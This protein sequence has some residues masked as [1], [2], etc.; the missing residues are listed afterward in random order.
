MQ[1][2]PARTLA[3]SG[4]PLGRARSGGRTRLAP[5]I[6]AFKVIGSHDQPTRGRPD[7]V[8]CGVNPSSPPPRVW[9]KSRL[10]LLV[11][12]GWGGIPRLLHADVL[13]AGP[14]GTPS[15]WRTGALRD[16]L[17]PQFSFDPEGG[18]SGH[19]G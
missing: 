10:L 6:L 11:L 2:K 17:R 9:L 18:R 3:F 15:G 1:P 19:G 13:A 5:V 8:Y 12:L 16:E 14:E 7:M 4:S